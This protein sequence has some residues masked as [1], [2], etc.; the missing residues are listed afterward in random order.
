MQQIDFL[1]IGDIVTEPFIKITDA[2]AT[3]DLDREN[4]KLSLRFGDKVPYE[5]AEICRAV[6]NSANASVA[7][8]RLGLSSYLVSYIGDDEIGK[9]NLEELA[10]NNV[11]TDFVKTCAGFPSTT[12]TYC[13]TTLN[14]QFSSNTQNFLTTWT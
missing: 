4:C 1:A 6:G 8:S 3:C 14:A 12:I 10:K 7:A 9:G 2:E 5:S 11:K 13:G